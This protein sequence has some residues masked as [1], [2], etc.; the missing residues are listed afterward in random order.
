VDERAAA[1]AWLERT[2]PRG[3]VLWWTMLAPALDPIREDPRFQRLLNEARPPGA[4]R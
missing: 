2:R 1:V 4:P 3:A